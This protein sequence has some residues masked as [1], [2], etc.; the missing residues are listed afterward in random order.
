MVRSGSK[1]P[2]VAA[3]KKKRQ[4]CSIDDVISAVVAGCTDSGILL[5]YHDNVHLLYNLVYFS[6]VAGLVLN[7]TETKKIELTF[8]KT[9]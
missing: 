9:E 6:N 1:D 7:G 2:Q 5:C 3:V 8:Q 4:S